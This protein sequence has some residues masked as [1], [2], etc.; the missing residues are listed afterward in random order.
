[1][2]SAWTSAAAESLARIRCP[3]LFLAFWIDCKTDLLSH[4]ILYR[5]WN[6]YDADS[7]CELVWFQVRAEKQSQVFEGKPF[8]KC[9]IRRFINIPSNPEKHFG[10]STASQMKKTQQA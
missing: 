6:Y 5:W 2:F 10:R 1:M 3:H 7:E 4:S 9:T 8:S